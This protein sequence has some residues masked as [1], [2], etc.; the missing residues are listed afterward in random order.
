MKI[1]KKIETVL[2]REASYKVQY[3][4]TLFLFSIRTTSVPVYAYFFLRIEGFNK[5]SFGFP[6]NLNLKKGLYYNSRNIKLI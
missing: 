1:S 3:K 5:V 4:N 2:I 6:E